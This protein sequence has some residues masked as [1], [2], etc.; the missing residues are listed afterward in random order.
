M[1]EMTLQREVVKYLSGLE[2]CWFVKNIPRLPD[3]I[4]SLDGR[5]FAIELKRPGGKVRLHQ[6]VS[7]KI[8]NALG[9]EAIFADSI[10][11]V[12]F[13]IALLKLK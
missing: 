2:R 10:E 7:V 1:K 9:A 8:M 11:Q 5:F 13:F 3:I 12:R 6:K 4:G